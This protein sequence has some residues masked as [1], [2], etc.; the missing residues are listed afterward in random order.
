MKSKNQEKPLLNHRKFSTPFRLCR[1]VNTR[2]DIKVIGMVYTK[3]E[4]ILF[5]EVIAKD[6]KKKKPYP[7]KEK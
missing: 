5:Y 2:G 1:F 4:F 6:K 7:N 3:L